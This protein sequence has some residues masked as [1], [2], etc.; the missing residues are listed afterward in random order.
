MRRSITYALLSIHQVG[1]LSRLQH[2]NIIG[3]HDAFLEDGQLCIV[4]ELASGSM[5]NR[6]VLAVPWHGSAMLGS[7]RLAA[8]GGSR[9]LR[10]EVG[11]LGTA[12][13]LGDRASRFQSRRFHRL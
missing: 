5:L 3:Y 9:H 8:P 13:A 12:T 7:G 11:P 4:M 1:L 10:R 6:A 2:P